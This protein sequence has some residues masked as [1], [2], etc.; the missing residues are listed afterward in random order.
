MLFLLS[1]IT[2]LDRVCIS[3]AM[4]QMSKELGL[5]PSQIGWVFGI[6][7]IAYGILKSLAVGWP[8]ASVPAKS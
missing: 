4:P 8:T 3:V 7:T 1:I 2:Y 5:S 6:F